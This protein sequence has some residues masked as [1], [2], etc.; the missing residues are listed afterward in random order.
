MTVPA[1]QQAL[2]NAAL[3]GSF[4]QQGPNL[5]GSGT[6]VLSQQPVPGTVV[7]KGSN[8]VVK[9]A[10]V[11][12]NITTVPNLVGLTVQQAEA[13]LTAKNLN[14]NFVLQGPAN[15]FLP[16]KVVSQQTAPGTV[17]A[18]GTTITA[19]YKH[20]VLV[21]PGQVVVPN[22]VNMNRAQAKA[23]LEA[24][25]FQTQFNGPPGPA[26]KRRVVN[27]NPNAGAAA[28]QGATITMTV[29]VIP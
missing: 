19:H 22:V 11:G 4:Q 14:G 17:V 21:P 1:A 29:V 13:A 26:H 15:P 6:K 16:K 9:Y 23:A 8:V 7:S 18:K 25:G 12:L 20:G 24:L 2:A 10:E 5:P 27:Q 28:P 3:Q